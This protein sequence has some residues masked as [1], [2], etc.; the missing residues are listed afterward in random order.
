MNSCIFLTGSVTYAIKAKRLLAESSILVQTTKV[1]SHRGRKGCIYG[2]EFP[3]Q[4]A[5]N[6]RRILESA[7]IGFEEYTE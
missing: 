7:G 4:Q 5:N 3:C 1:S 2:I 6:I